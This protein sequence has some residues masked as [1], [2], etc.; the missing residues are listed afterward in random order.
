MKS[1]AHD[2]FFP[3]FFAAGDLVNYFF[4]YVF[5]GLRISDKALIKYF[6]MAI[7]FNDDDESAFPEGRKKFVMHHT[8]EPDSAITRKA[9]RLQFEQ[10]GKLE[11]EVCDF[12]FSLHYG[13]P[14]EGFIEAH[15]RVPVSELNGKIRTKI[16]DLALVCSNCHRMLHRGKPLPTVESLRSLLQGEV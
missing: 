3:F 16:G 2:W 4:L 13:S 9:K 6:F 12:D 10:T 1:T 5:T 8:R 7:Y 14:G 15:H 11:C